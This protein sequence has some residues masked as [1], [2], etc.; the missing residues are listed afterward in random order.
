MIKK[1][2]VFVVL[3]LSLIFL[4]A[5]KQTDVKIENSIKAIQVLK[6]YYKEQYNQSEEISN[7]T[8]NYYVWENDS[9]YYVLAL[10]SLGS[11]GVAVDVNKNEI[12]PPADE[13]YS[14]EQVVNKKYKE[15]KKSPD[16]QEINNSDVKATLKVYMRELE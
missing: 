10:S 4:V 15:E 6:K 2:R 11:S 16:Y 8:I 9:K 5:C 13:K 3:F 12:I 1:I 14:V 7:T